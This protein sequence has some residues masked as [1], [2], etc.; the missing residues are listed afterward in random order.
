M[1]GLVQVLGIVGK[2]VVGRLLRPPLFLVALAPVQNFLLI[3]F[4]LARLSLWLA[5]LAAD[6]PLSFL[7]HHLRTGNSLLG[8]SIGDLIN[9]PNPGISRG[10][11]LSR[12][13]PLFDEDSW[14]RTLRTAVP[15][16]LSLGLRPDDSVDS[17][18]DKTRILSEITARDSPLGRWKTVADVWCACWLWSAGGARL[19]RAAF[20]AV[21]DAVLGGRSPLPQHELTRWLSET[22]MLAAARRLFHWPLEFPEAFFDSLGDPLP[23]GGFHAVIGNPPWEMLRADHGSDAERRDMRVRG[24]AALHFIRRSGIYSL[25]RE[26][27]ANCYQ[28]FLERA[29]QL[30]ARGGR[31]G[32]VLPSGVAIDRGSAA[33]RHALLERTR[34]DTLLGFDNHRAIFPIH[35]SVRFLLITSTNTPCTRSVRARFG[36]SDPAWLD[37]VPD[38][39]AARPDLYPIAFTPALLRK[40]SGD[41]CTIPELRQPIDLQIREKIVSRVPALGD[42]DGWQAR[43]GRELNATD[44]RRHFDVAGHGLPVL[45][46]KHLDPFR[47]R[48]RDAR[49][50]I[51]ARDATRLLGAHT[52][53]RP[54]LA[55]R[56]VASA[57]NRLT[58]IAAIVPRGAVTTHTLFCLKTRLSTEEQ[59]F[60]CGVFNSF[61]ANYLVRPQV[62]THVTAAIVERLPVP[63]P[64]RAAPAFAA[65]SALAR[66][67]A[68]TPTDQP[69]YATLQAEVA[70]LYGLTVHEFAHVLS[71]FPLV[72]E[73]V[74]EASLRSAERILAGRT[75]A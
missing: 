51:H 1:S 53:T 36:I 8:A 14:E 19:P 61:V 20:S 31:I 7:D 22:H 69:A 41:A 49:H 57:T 66:Q 37:S 54:R 58:L 50:A 73:G 40:W 39:A 56:E 9:R 15:A 2:D 52:F 26:G 47:V 59:W 29:L 4:Q 28:L 64:A 3:F 17:V 11:A 48:V 74:R 72:Q 44:D 23:D 45:E 30:A 34:V 18:R 55:Y 10:T 35:R 13:L 16:R 33:L 65:I 27:H 6:A 62:S 70:Q 67:L 71:T 42:P 68:R 43:F 63:K 25:V 5:T 32:L 12:T 24:A 75:T 38:E 21:S 60:L 46:G